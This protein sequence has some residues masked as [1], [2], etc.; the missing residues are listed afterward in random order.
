MQR[1]SRD[2][3]LDRPP[4]PRW[5]AD[6]PFLAL[7]GVEQTEWREGYCE[8]QLRL[9]AEL[10]NRQ[11]FVQ[12]GVIATLL[13]V[14]CGY[15]G[16]FSPPPREPLYGHTVSLALNFLNKGAGGLVVAK[17][18]VEQRGRTL[19]FARGEAWLDGAQLLAT[20]QGSFK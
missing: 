1:I 20:A 3:T 4:Q 9:R 19:F 14:A 8:F 2:D 15:A 17:G 6:N 18:F 16:L 12:G 10:L 7:L 11:G 13:D 5:S